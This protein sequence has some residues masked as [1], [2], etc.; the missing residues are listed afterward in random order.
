VQYITIQDIF[1]NMKQKCC[2]KIG[3]RFDK[4]YGQNIS[5]LAGSFPPK[6]AASLQNI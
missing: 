2:N 3:L 1:P 4:N 6:E 5:N